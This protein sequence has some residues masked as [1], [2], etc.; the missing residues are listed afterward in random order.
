M[1]SL[2]WAAKKGHVRI[3]KMLCNNGADVN[4]KD[5]IGRTPLFFAIKYNH[6]DIA[7]VASVLF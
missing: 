4:A 5:L 7:K 2:H 6:P 3:V 1:T